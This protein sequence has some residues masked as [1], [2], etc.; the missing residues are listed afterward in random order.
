MILKIGIALYCYVTYI[1]P[2]EVHS[3][4]NCVDHATGH[5]PFVKYPPVSSDVAL[6]MMFCWPRGR[7]TVSYQLHVV[8]PCSPVAAKDCMLADLV[9]LSVL[10]TLYNWSI[11]TYHIPFV[12]KC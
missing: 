3:S 6:L 12:Q 2:G 5:Y 9:N 10:I 11:T 1:E 8:K 7:V 4:L